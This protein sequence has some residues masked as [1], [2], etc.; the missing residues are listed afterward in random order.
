MSFRKSCDVCSNIW[1][2]RHTN[3]FAFVIFYNQC[4]SASTWRWFDLWTVQTEYSFH[5]IVLRTSWSSL[6]R[7][8]FW[9]FFH[10]NTTGSPSTRVR[11]IG[12]PNNLSDNIW[13]DAKQQNEVGEP[14]KRCRRHY[15]ENAPS[16]VERNSPNNQ[17]LDRKGRWRKSLSLI[18]EDLMSNLPEKRGDPDSWMILP[19]RDDQLTGTLIWGNDKRFHSNTTDSPSTPSISRYSGDCVNHSIWPFQDVTDLWYFAI[20]PRKYWIRE[21][22]YL[23]CW[24]LD[25][26]VV[27]KVLLIHGILF[28]S[29]VNIVYFL[30]LI[31]DQ[32]LWNIT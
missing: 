15:G 7:C 9:E 16:R 23:C 10:L 27:N 11:D 5:P 12:R 1:S 22:V 14:W 29:I 25:S 19:W 8:A 24:Y 28:Q 26:L 6:Q 13:H 3:F 17:D 18:K 31:L 21:I 4:R 32:F 2:I 30:I 20:F